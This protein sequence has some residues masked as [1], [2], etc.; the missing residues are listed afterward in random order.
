MSR[1]LK[2]GADYPTAY[3]G[4]LVHLVQIT[5]DTTTHF[6]GERPVSYGGHDY[7][8]YLIFDSPVRRYRSLQADVAE[9]KLANTDGVIEALLN[10][11]RFEGAKCI[12]LEYFPDL[13]SPDAAELVR[14]VLSEQQAGEDVVSWRMIP[15]Y[16]FGAITLP[17]RQFATT[18]SWRYQ[19][20]P[21]GSTSGQA[22]CPKDYASCLVRG[23]THRFN[24]FVQI[25]AQLVRLYPP[26]PP[27]EPDD[28]GRPG[29]PRRPY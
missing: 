28:R 5:T 9:L 16:D 11:E 24:A 14:G 19:S 18:C 15:E 17:D 21:C 2:S 4:A 27:R 7:T 22:T 12:L 20:P 13:G 1:K 26:V 6:Y 10:A 8:S 29:G 23:A 25:T 3:T